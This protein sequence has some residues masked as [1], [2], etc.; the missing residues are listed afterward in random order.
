MNEAIAAPL[1]AVTTLV[2]F[3]QS[4]DPISGGAGWI[5]AGLLGAVLSWLCLVHLPAK[6]KQLHEILDG[7]ASERSKFQDTLLMLQ[8][9]ATTESRINREAFVAGNTE[10]RQAIELQTVKLEQAIA[11]TCKHQDRGVSI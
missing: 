7:Q 8:Q 5:G 11:G 4:T 1:A 10:L 3:A 6:D 9:A 2:L